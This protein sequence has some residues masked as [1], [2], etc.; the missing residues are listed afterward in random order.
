MA[1]ITCRR[2]NGTHQSAKAVR[3]CF[4]A[5]GAYWDRP[6]QGIYC[7]Y[8][9]EIGTPD[10]HAGCLDEF[11]AQQAG[12]I[13][14]EAKMSWIA[15][16]GSPEDANFYAN[17]IASGTSW[18]EHLAARGEE[19]AREAEAA[20]TCDHGLSALLCEGPNHDPAYEQE[21]AYYGY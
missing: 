1:S 9:E 8:H 17:V 10:E 18:E 2:C 16:G 12:E 7:D 14:A 21:R 15:G 6:G 20:G 4:D 13:Y 11:A 3:I 5:Q 19:F